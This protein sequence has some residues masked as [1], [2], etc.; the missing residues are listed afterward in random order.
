MKI[1][2]II[3]AVIALLSVTSCSD[4]LDVKPSDRIS[5]QV[6]FSSL[7]GFRQALNGIYVELN[8][9]Q[10]YGRTL[11]CEFVEIIA[12]RYAVLAENKSATEIM[13]LYYGGSTA[14][15]RME[16]TWGKAY[17]LIA[18]TNLIIKNCEDNR[19][20]L[21]DEYYHLIKGEAY[22]LRA[23]LHFDLY[24]LFGYAY[25]T[26][27]SSTAI[28]YYDSFQLN[29]SPTLNSHEYMEKVI[30][31]LT[32]AENELQDD[33][34]IRYGVEGN[35]KDVFLS[36]RNLRLN[37]YAVQ[38]LL[39]RVYYYMSHGSEIDPANP[40][41]RRLAYEYARKVVD[42]QE[43]YFP[44]VNATDALTSSVVDHVFSSEV[45]FALQNLSRESL[46]SSYFNANNVKANSLLGCRNDV[47]SEVFGGTKAGQDYRY[48]ANFPNTV[49]VGSTSYRVFTKFEGTDSLYAQ[50]IPMIRVSEAYLIVAELGPDDNERLELFNNFRE[51]RGISERTSDITE[52]EHDPLRHTS[53]LDGEWIKEF[54]GEG[55]LFFWYKCHGSTGMRS[56]TDPTNNTPYYVTS[57]SKYVIPIPDA[58]TKYN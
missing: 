9:D 33:P 2:T 41:Y 18:N 42:I 46:Y 54:I 51:H 27:T 1:K 38:G 14:M 17:N 52:L 19:A 11:S 35:P 22:A 12:Q 43:A 16:S 28:P 58:E 29:V 15:S 24:R 23:Y 53:L 31:D 56:A 5:E 3:S 37:L 57:P 36:Y 8:S 26:N 34:I 6:N 45:M 7:A 49:S 13:N 39:A 25:R 20:V 21:P 48:R 32:I 40:E 10:L 44:W 50:M 30:A 47:I 55:Q 4:Y